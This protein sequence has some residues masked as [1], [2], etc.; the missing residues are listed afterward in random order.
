MLRLMFVKAKDEKHQ[1]LRQIELNYLDNGDI[2]PSL[3]PVR[4]LEGD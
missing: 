3:V 1:F 4:M 2:H